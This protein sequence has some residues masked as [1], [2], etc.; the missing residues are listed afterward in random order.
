MAGGLFAD[1]LPLLRRWFDKYQK[2]RCSL[3]A[4]AIA[5][6]ALFSIIPVTALLVAV[7]SRAVRIPEVERQVVD[8]VIERIPVA[9]GLVVDAL[10]A[11]SGTSEPLSIVGA[12]L[13]LWAAMGIFT[14]LR[15][16][17]NIVWGVNPKGLVKQRF[18]DIAAI[19]GLG[20]LVV[21]S[22]AGTAALHSLLGSGSSV[23]GSLP[24]TRWLLEL[25][26]AVLP[27]TVTFVAFLLVYRY[28]P[29]VTVTMQD[30][31]PGAV[32]GAAL[33]EAAKHGFTWYV[34]TFSGAQ[35]YGALGTVM[36][37]QLWVYVSANVLLAGAE[38][39][40]V[41]ATAQGSPPPELHPSE[42]REL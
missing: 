41:L 16:V 19:F 37:F 2:D 27:A 24:R 6:R 14:T 3:L 33:F 18:V 11:I 9:R 17:L 34:S 42:S 22:I 26:S 21:L 32:V 30:V 5:Y 4:S 15:E 31:L 12:I 38:L 36:L 8:L 1:G 35:V 13:L 40:A 39:N 20:A 29:Y 23:M 10:R 28:V 7:V 25:V